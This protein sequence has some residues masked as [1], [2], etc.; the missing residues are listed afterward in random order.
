MEDVVA[1]RAEFIDPA[2]CDSIVGY[3]IIN[4]SQPWGQLTLTDCSR[5]IDWQFYEGETPDSKIE[6]AIA[7]LVEFRDQLKKARNTK[8]AKEAKAKRDAKEAAKQKAGQS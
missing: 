2:D 6:K 3:K 4:S 5:K 1:S 8:V 7:M